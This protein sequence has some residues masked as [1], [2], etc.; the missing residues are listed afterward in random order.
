MIGKVDENT[1]IGSRLNDLSGSSLRLIGLARQDC[2]EIR[3][4][5]VD[6]GVVLEDA[7]VHIRAVRGVD[8]G[9]GERVVGLVIRNVVLVNHNNLIVWNSTT[10]DNLVSVI[11]VGLAEVTQ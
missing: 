6:T 1:V 4:C 10:L 8:D 9:A 5:C 3:G 7:F 2:V 11:N